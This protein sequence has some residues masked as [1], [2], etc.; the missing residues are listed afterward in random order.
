MYSLIKSKKNLV[1]LILFVTLFLSCNITNDKVKVVDLTSEYLE[2]PL[3]IDKISPRL[4]WKIQTDEYNFRQNAYQI[5]AASS[6][7]NLENNIGDIWDSGK[8]VSNE[9]TQVKYAGGEFKITPKSIL[10]GSCLG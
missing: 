6:L 4:S 3:G 1:C 9:S 10:E 7:R 5:L 2:N 8:V